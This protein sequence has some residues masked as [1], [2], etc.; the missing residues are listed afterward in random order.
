M[1]ET[2]VFKDFIEK[3]KDICVEYINVNVSK[4]CGFSR[5]ECLLINEAKENL[6]SGLYNKYE[7]DDEDTLPLKDLLYNVSFTM[8]NFL[9]KD[10][11]KLS[12][13]EE[14]LLKDLKSFIVTKINLKD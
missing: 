13:S 9:Q 3:L 1:N 7:Y 5:R 6:I 2:I 10:H 11:I 4:G 12:F 8:D 14:L